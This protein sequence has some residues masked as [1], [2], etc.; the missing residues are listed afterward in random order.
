LRRL[1]ARDYE[2]RGEEDVVAVYTVDAALR[3]V[4]EDI[5]VEGGLADALGDIVFFRKGLTSGLVL[6]E[7]DAE[8]EA[9]SSDFADVRMRS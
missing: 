2:G 8:E 1:F 9:E 3:G 7:F 6:Y 5:F 4:G